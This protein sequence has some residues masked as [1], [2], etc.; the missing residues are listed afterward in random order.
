MHNKFR[1]IP[2]TL[3]VI[4]IEL[5]CFKIYNEIVAMQGLND[6]VI[7]NLDIKKSIR[8]SEN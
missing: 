4:D 2:T 6:I 1:T 5:I 3:L 8:L 7:F